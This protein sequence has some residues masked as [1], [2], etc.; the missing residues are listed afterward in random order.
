MTRESKLALVVGFG[1][2]LFVGI[3]VAD[4]LS[5]VHRPRTA[6]LLD[7]L[8]AGGEPPARATRGISEL[9]NPDRPAL[10][11]TPSAS[12]PADRPDLRP[13]H[14]AGWPQDGTLVLGG[15]VRVP[16]EAAGPTP[17]DVIVRRPDDGSLNPGGL[18]VVDPLRSAPRV[19]VVQR[20]E[21]P[22]QIASEHLGSGGR[23]K[24]L[25]A[26]NKISDPR[27][28]RAGMRLTLPSAPVPPRG[29]IV[30]VS[31]AGSGTGGAGTPAQYEEY[32]V[33]AG[34]TLSK[35][36]RERLGGVGQWPK[37]YEMNRD[38][39]GSP[40]NMRPGTVI[41]IPVARGGGSVRA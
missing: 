2:V 11:V 13:D 9:G 8:L 14:G 5:A 26:A 25:L 36:A 41:R 34:D 33:R 31:Q 28:L 6:N 30:R 16:P 37:L 24:E 1:L 23:W 7:P 19:H 39:L 35:I 4:Q 21:T 20:G 38:R 27:Q 32:T 29:E 40:N 10:A 17:D 12:A 15:P 18:P 22:Y 3:L